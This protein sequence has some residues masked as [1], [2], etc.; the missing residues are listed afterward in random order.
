LVGKLLLGSCAERGGAQPSAGE[1]CW[2]FEFSGLQRR[3]GMR[4]RSSSLA[5]GKALPEPCRLNETY[6]RLNDKAPLGR[7]EPEHSQ[8]PDPTRLSLAS[9]HRLLGPASNLAEHHARRIVWSAPGSQRRDAARFLRAG[10]RAQTLDPGSLDRH[11][12]RLHPHHPPVP[13]RSP[14]EPHRSPT[15]G[16]R[17]NPAHSPAAL[18][19]LPT[20]RTTT[21]RLAPL[22]PNRRRPTPR[23]LAR[24]GLPLTTQTIRQARSLCCAGIGITAPQR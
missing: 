21:H 16:T 17:P 20:Q 22:A 12:R 2:W 4:A 15:P 1:G 8:A 11:V 14:R 3:D 6:V 19:R 7:R 18:P 5:N 23:P 10:G 9:R 13:A 24:V